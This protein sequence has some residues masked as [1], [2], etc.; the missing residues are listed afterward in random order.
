[1]LSKRKL[2]NLVKNIYAALQAE[3]EPLN[4]QLGY[5]GEQETLQ[6]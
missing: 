4:N 3:I 2:K 1:M 6:A 5:K